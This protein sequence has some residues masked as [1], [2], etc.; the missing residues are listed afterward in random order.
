MSEDPMHIEHKA[1]GKRIAKNTII[2]YFRML[3]V[4]G[5][6]LYTSRVVLDKLGAS[7]YGIY[8]AVGGVVGMLSFLTYT[9][10]TGTSRFLTFEIGRNDF[11]KLRLTFSTAFYVHLLLALIVAVILC[12]G[13]AWFVLNKLI[14]PEERLTAAFGV[15]VISAI[16]TMVSIT[17]VPYTSV[18][19]AHE[20]MSV[21]AYIGIFEAA[22]KLGIA[23][24][25]SIGHWDRLIFFAILMAFVQIAVA[26]LYR[27]FCIKHY[28][29]SK[30]QRC[31]D[32]GIFKEIISF[33]GWT[34]LANFSHVLS[35]QGTAVLVSMFFQPSIVAAKTIG[36]RI[37]TTML[38]F[39]NNFRTAI[40]PQVIKL[41]ANEDYAESRK[42]T[43]QS[44]I[45]VFD[46]VILLAL[47]LIVLMKPLLDL[48][49]VNVPEYTV[50]FAQIIVATE[51]IN[52]YNGTLYVPMTASARLKENSLIGVS[53]TLV[54]FALLYLLLKNGYSVM[55][56]LYIRA[57]AIAVHSFVVKP[58]LLSKFVPDYKMRHFFLNEFDCA[59][60]AVFPVIVSFLIYKYWLTTGFVFVALK[61]MAIMASVC[62]S[63]VLFMDKETKNRLLCFIRKK[64]TRN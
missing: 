30:L 15:L 24:L 1:N 56:V 41:Y 4:M 17:Q 37:S 47:P 40:T 6:T 7:D 31:F 12:S 13:G 45:Y 62:F 64:M 9:L 32:K 49:L 58:I 39:V 19:I 22:A 46:L 10:N 27:V 55:W 52:V 18:I 11:P 29:E 36:E 59:K 57:A 42:L 44:S 33:S 3:L 35:T 34:L 60:I 21:Y 2:L 54:T 38:T 25:I 5:V 63:S 20:N 14:I 50:E 28:Q 16:T 8:G 43:L 26:M 53:I 51:I 48:W 61:G 23:F